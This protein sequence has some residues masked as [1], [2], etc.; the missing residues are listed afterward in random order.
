MGHTASTWQPALARAMASRAV[1]YQRDVVATK[2]V[3]RMEATAVGAS[4]CTLVMDIVLRHTAAL[5][6]LGETDR[7]QNQRYTNSPRL[8]I[9]WLAASSILTTRRPASPSF[10]GASSLVMHATK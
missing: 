7:E 10:I 1:G 2:M 8:P 9:D 5:S 4:Q 6:I 3:G